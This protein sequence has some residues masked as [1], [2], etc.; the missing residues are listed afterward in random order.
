MYIKTR[1]PIYL[2]DA[3]HNFH[4]SLEPEC[5]E[6]K[7]LRIKYLT[8]FL[9]AVESDNLWAENHYLKKLLTCIRYGNF[10]KYIVE[11]L[12]K[13]FNQRAEWCSYYWLHFCDD[14]KYDEALTTEN[15]SYLLNNT[16]Y[17]FYVNDAHE[18]PYFHALKDDLRKLFRTYKNN[19]FAS[20]EIVAKYNSC[21]FLFKYSHMEADMAH[22]FDTLGIDAV[23]Q[24]EFEDLLSPV[25]TKL[26]FDGYVLKNGNPLL[27]E[28]QGIQHY[29]PI[30]FFGGEKTFHKV[31]LY[32]EIKKEWCRDHEIPL[33]CIKYNRN[34]A[35]SIEKFIHRESYDDIIYEEG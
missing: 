17:S 1:R 2:Y 3:S 12:Y 32:D 21:R 31:K 10:P 26:R 8:K 13:V 16:L 23:Y 20:E 14:I 28:C 18:Y 30:A 29:Q 27:F 4:D 6:Y 33:L 34:V 9:S 35:S 24:K 15:R 11:G 19:G 22:A 7:R 25:G 5:D